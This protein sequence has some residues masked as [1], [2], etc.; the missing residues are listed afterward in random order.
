MAGGNLS[1]RQ[2]MINLMYLV[3]I[4]M[5]AMNMSKEVL[6]SFGFLNEKLTEANTKATLKN[7]AALSLLSGKAAEQ[8]EKYEPLRLKADQ[9]KK[10]SDGLYND[11]ENLKKE[12]TESLP[13]KKDYEVMD[14]SKF[15]DEYFFSVSMQIWCALS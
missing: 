1:P 13:D 14:Q 7:D 2:K 8:K 5:L 15:L 11:I 6:S 9:I 10:L 12:M 4:A 3:F